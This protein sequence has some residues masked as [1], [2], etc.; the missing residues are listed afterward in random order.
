MHHCGDATLGEL[1]ALSKAGEPIMRSAHVGNQYIAN[2]VLAKHGIRTT[3]Y[4]RTVGCRDR[5]YQPHR[6]VRLNQSAREVVCRD[7]L[8]VARTPAIHPHLEVMRSAFPQTQIIPWGDYL[9]LHDAETLPIL[10]ILRLFE[11]SFD[12]SREQRWKRYVHESGRLEEK[13]P[14]S[15]R[16]VE[17]EGVF[18]VNAETHGWL[19]PNIFNVLLS[20]IFDH[21]EFGG[22]DRI[23]HLSGPDMVKYIKTMEKEL[24]WMW[25]LVSRRFRFPKNFEFRLYPTASLRFAT[26][27]ARSAAI[28]ALIDAYEAYGV[29]RDRKNEAVRSAHTEARRSVIEEFDR[30]GA[31][32]NSVLNEVVEAIP[33]IFYDVGKDATFLTQH[34]VERHGLYDHPFMQEASF[35]TLAG[36]M[37]FLSGIRA[38]PLRTR[39]A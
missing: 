16:A 22:A 20:A 7:D 6:I 38:K 23:H 1:V 33:E 31:S 8:L 21:L 15:W 29:H 39:A 2:L 9:R 14:R 5:N 3:W 25:D 37:K 19:M 13:T 10:E 11:S 30:I 18:G 12:S 35:D 32:V 34:D 4:D 28:D 24:D 36:M 27:P 26:F 17:E